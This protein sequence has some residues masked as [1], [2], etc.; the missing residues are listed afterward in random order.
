MIRKHFIII[1]FLIILTK[2]H[3]FAQSVDL[4]DVLQLR[5]GT[6]A[7]TSY[8][9]NENHIVFPAKLFG[10]NVSEIRLN[11]YNTERVIK[12]FVIE[13]G[14]KKIASRS[15]SNDT[16]IIIYSFTDIILPDSILEIGDG[17]FYQS[18]STDKNVNL[19]FSNNLK[20]IGARAFSGWM[21]GNFLGTINVNSI[22]L[23]NSLE[24]V[25]TNAFENLDIKY[26]KIQNAFKVDNYTVFRNSIISCIEIC[27]NLSDE[28]L[29]YV[30][31][32]KGFVN[33][34]ISQGRR[35]NIYLYNGKIWTIGTRQDVERILSEK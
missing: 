6:L 29:N 28:W 12:S 30:F 17:A 11:V 3:V 14:I 32:D 8:K 7:I 35:A 18:L 22:I 21:R 33:F 34:Y 25:G 5:D 16:S 15:F 13:Y 24:Y 10:L 31:S 19:K 2:Y 20:R 27:A 23:P 1:F 26:L 9:G 4:F